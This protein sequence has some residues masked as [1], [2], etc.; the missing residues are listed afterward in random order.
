M[1]F[2]GK[3]AFITGGGGGIGTGLAEAFVEKGMKLVLADIDR[4]RAENE[5]AK[6]GTD[7][8]GLVIDVTSPESWAAAREAALA[9]FGPVEVLCNNAGVSVP[10]N[11]LVDVP[12]EDFERAFQVNVFGVYNGVKTFGPDMI[13]RKSG[14]IVNTSSFN[15]LISMGTM[16]P[17]SACK[18][19]VTALSVAL[20]QEMAPHGVGVSTIY[21]GATR[22]FMTSEIFDRYPDLVR[23]QPIM[24]PV[25]IGR[26]VIAA[27]EQNQPHVIS[28]PSLKSAYDAWV[29]EVLGS[30][31]EPAQPGYTG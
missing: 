30:F 3:T 7:A 12:P 13:A 1:K 20:R 8:M 6:F 21:P 26:A 4:D 25:W 31:G 18:F 16:G 23:T 15:G 28:H 29:E 10:W 5:A 24:E 17:Y 19:A 22:S 9:R 14:H 2:A 27:I 11:A